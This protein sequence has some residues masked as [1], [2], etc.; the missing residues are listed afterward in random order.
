MIVVDKTEGGIYNV[1][2]TAYN[3]NNGD[4]STSIFCR[5]YCII[6]IKQWESKRIIGINLLQPWV[7]VT[8]QQVHIHLKRHDEVDNHTF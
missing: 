2:F 4:I 1:T 6:N 7:W 8:Y 3:S 5:A